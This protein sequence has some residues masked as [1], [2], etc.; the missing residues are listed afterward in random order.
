MADWGIR[1]LSD[2]TKK[3]LWKIKNSEFGIQ[4]KRWTATTKRSRSDVV[5]TSLQG[6]KR[7]GNLGN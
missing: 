1:Q 4:R 7:C 2:G 3:E 6:A 5:G